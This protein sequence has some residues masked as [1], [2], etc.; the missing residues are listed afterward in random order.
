[1]RQ[2]RL[3]RGI[4]IRLHICVRPNEDAM[5]ALSSGTAFRAACSVVKALA[6]VLP[7]EL[8]PSLEHGERRLGWRL[9]GRCTIFSMQ[10]CSAQNRSQHTDKTAKPLAVNPSS[11]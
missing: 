5:A 4:E 10:T 2:A 7:S 9:R 8:S 11:S 6:H 1:M 3:V